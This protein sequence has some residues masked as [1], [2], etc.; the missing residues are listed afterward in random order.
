MT[1]PA[2]RQ[3]PATKA[4]RWVGCLALAVL[5]LSGVVLTPVAADAKARVVGIVPGQS[6]GGV[7]LGDTPAQVK[8]A[9]GKPSSCTPLSC[10][11]T[12]LTWDYEH[13][14]RGFEGKVSFNHGRVDAMWTTSNRLMTS[15]GI[16]TIGLTGH[17]RGSSVAEIEQAYPTA[18][19]EEQPDAQG[20]TTCSLTST[21]HGQAVQTGFEIFTT[22]AGLAEISL[23]YVSASKP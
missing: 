19:C 6:I 16:H 17:G 14:S 22:A 21:Y 15:K 7:K 3:T 4:G 9:L 20:Y 8:H 18:K 12:S 10:H 13:E 5:S 1:P 11:A 2:D 23:E